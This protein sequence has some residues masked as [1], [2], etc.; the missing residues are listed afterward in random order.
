MTIENVT[1]ANGP[2]IPGTVPIWDL[3]YIASCLVWITY[4]E[5]KGAR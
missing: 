5:R 4:V 2:M 3:I 1:L